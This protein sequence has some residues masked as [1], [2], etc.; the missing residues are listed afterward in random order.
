MNRAPLSVPVASRLCP[1]HLPATSAVLRTAP[2]VGRPALATARIPK[3]ASRLSRLGRQ[4]SSLVAGLV[5]ALVVF[6]LVAPSSGAQATPTPYAAGGQISPLVETGLTTPRWFT[7]TDGQVHLAYELWLT[8]PLPAPVTVGA[9]EVFDADAGTTLMRLEGDT[10]LAAMTLVALPEEPA[11]LLPPSTVA[12]VWFDVPLAAE[13]DLPASI[14]HRLT[15]TLPPEMPVADSILSY[16]GAAVAVDRR[17][18]VILGAPLAGPGWAALGSCCDGPHRRALIPIDGQSYLAQR[19]AIDFNLLDAENRPGTGDPRLFTSFPTYGESVLAVTDATVVEA[20]DR[21]PDLLVGESREEVT[22]STAGGNR[23]IL[24]IGDGRFAI[25]AHLQAG[26][27]TVRTGDRIE[28][29]QRIAGVGSSGTSGGPHLHFQVT[30]H[31]S[32]MVADGLPYVFDAFEVTGQTPPMAEV[33]PYYDTLEP[34]PLTTDS[35][36]PRRNALPLGRDVVTFP[37]ASARDEGR[38]ARTDTV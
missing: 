7:G 10:L 4:R 26:S 34:I 30:D 16:T 24:D 25:Y 15:V 21:Y 17:P 27:V 2:A 23:I 18:P 19:F 8:N 36:G 6:G 13:G 32:I 9:V 20:V 5:T 12:V 3:D 31:P 29:G 22:P 38:L 11:V 37:R 28:R 14:A 1:P 35:T 33:L